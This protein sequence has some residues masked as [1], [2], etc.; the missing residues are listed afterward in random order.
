MLAIRLPSFGLFSSGEQKEPALS[1]M[2]VHPEQLM[3]ITALP[4]S[5]RWHVDADPACSL[6]WGHASGEYH[7][8]GTGLSPSPASSEPLTRYKL[9]FPTA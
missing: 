4:D 2:S 9:S 3:T 8:H 5:C 1:A 6:E 7:S